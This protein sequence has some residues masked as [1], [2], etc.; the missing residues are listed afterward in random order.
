MARLV[1]VGLASAGDDGGSTIRLGCS[2]AHVRELE[3]VHEFAFLRLGEVPVE[4]KEWE[5]GVQDVLALPYYDAG[6]FAV[7]PMIDPGFEMTYDRIPK[8]EV[9]IRRNSGVSSQDGH[10]L[11][12]VDGFL[13]ADDGQITH[14]V[15]HRGHLWGER[16]ITVPIA[17]VARVRTDAVTLALTKDAVGALPSIPVRRWPGRRGDDA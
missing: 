4:D 8:G 14:L 9:E 2:A 12:R 16:E 17:A 15:L 6:G 3:T 11:G 5:V 10:D 1:P 13:V 7:T